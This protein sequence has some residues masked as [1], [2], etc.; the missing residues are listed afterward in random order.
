MTG[1]LLWQII[2][3]TGLPLLGF[4]YMLLW[5]RIDVLV[6]ALQDH[7]KATSGADEKLH[8]RL[9]GHNRDHIQLREVTDLKDRLKRIEEKID[10]VLERHD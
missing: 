9:D 4:L 6:K 5:R 2:T 8:E 1:Q 3:S 7:I 10:R